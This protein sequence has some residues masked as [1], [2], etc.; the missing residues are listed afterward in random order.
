MPYVLPVFGVVWSTTLRIMGYEMEMPPPKEEEFV[1]SLITG[2]CMA[3]FVDLEI[4]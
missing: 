4:G 3:S 2:Q 1:K